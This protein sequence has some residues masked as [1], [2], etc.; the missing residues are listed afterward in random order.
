LASCGLA[1]S[2]GAAIRKVLGQKLDVRPFLDLVAI[3]TVADVAP[4]TGDNRILVRAGLGVLSSGQR[5]GLR[6]LADNARI[7][8]ARGI[9]AEHIA[10]RIAPRLNATGRLGDPDISLD[11]LLESSPVKA[12]ALASVVEQK[13][14]ERRAIQQQMLVE[15]FTEIERSGFARAPAIVLAREGWHPGVVGIVAGR[16]A[17]RLRRPTIVIALEGAT[18]RGSVRGPPGA[19]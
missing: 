5:P 10:S 15:A 7:E 19:L 14:Q 11:L 13:S 9:A 8:L 1:L 17:S 6:A 18:G 12:V 16:I 3:G 2:L 4:L